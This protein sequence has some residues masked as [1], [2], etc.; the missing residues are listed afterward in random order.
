MVAATAIGG[1]NIPSLRRGSRADQKMQRY[2]NAIGAA[3]G[4][5]TTACQEKRRLM[6]DLPRFALSEVALHFFIGL[7]APS[8][9]RGYL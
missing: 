7:S 8:L 3:W 5:Q 9:R 4:G 2:L 1:F 6:S